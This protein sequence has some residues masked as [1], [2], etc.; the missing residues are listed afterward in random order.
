V[1]ATSRFEQQTPLM[2]MTTSTPVD[3]NNCLLGYVFAACTH[4]YGHNV[5]KQ[6]ERSS[7]LVLVPTACSQS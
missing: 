5:P 4:A 1:L 7:V 6:G 2:A 3:A